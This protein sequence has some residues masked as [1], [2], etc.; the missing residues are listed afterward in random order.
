[1]RIHSVIYVFFYSRNDEI[2]SEVKLDEYSIDDL[3][4]VSKPIE[5]ND[6]RFISD[7]AS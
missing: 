7:L 3:N 1:M 2:E 5:Q 6:M 4:E